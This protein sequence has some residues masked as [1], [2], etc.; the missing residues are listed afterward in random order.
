MDVGAH[1][2][3]L[4]PGETL[5]R[6]YS[7]LLK[8]LGYQGW[9]PARTR[10]EVIV[11]AILTQNTAWHNAALALKQLRAAGLLNWAALR[12]ASPAELE[13]CVRSAGFYRQ[14]ARTIRTFADWLERSHGGSLNALFSH[15][16]PELRNNLLNLNGLGTETVDAI[17]LYAGRKPS[18]VADAYTRRILIR[19]GLLPPS[20][21]YQQAQDFLHQNLPADAAM[22]NEFHAL[23]VE[24]GKQFCGRSHPHC[25][26]CPLEGFLPKSGEPCFQ[27]A[28]EASP[29][30][31][32][33]F[34]VETA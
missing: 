9:W 19:H 29:E 32:V 34:E 7:S 10:L 22:F 20:A 15:P 2:P 17:I 27:Q 14:K 26:G 31:R 18:F 5:Q 12:E 25:A 33:P 3:D 6:F 21:G 8:Q 11:G 24:T 23:L 16:V 30:A 4:A 28:E 1:P 13:K